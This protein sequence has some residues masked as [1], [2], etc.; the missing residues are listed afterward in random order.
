MTKEQPCADP[1]PNLQ[2]GA[3]S[4][5]RATNGTLGIAA[6]WLLSSLV[7]IGVKAW[8]LRHVTTQCGI[9]YAQVSE[10]SLRFWSLSGSFDYSECEVIVARMYYDIRSMLRVLLWVGVTALFA[11]I[12][13][14]RVSKLIKEARSIAVVATEL[15][16]S[17]RVEE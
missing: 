12:A 3:L 11:N 17:G 4:A 6:I 7:E 1:E 10:T 5:Q 13:R 8:R 15:P 2:R 16:N 14:L 9:G